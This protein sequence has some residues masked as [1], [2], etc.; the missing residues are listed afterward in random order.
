MA[1]TTTAARLTAA[2]LE[3]VL[4]LY[5]AVARVASADVPYVSDDAVEGDGRGLAD[6]LVDALAGIGVELLD[7]T[8][9]ILTLRAP[10]FAMPFR[11]V[12]RLAAAAREIEAATAAY[13]EDLL[14]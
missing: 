12:K 14:D 7:S 10:L 9:G 1:T 3:K 8:H 5:E 11:D 13:G 6:C 4:D 2:Q